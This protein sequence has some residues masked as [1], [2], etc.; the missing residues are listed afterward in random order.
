M[1]NQNGTVKQEFNEEEIQSVLSEIKNNSPE[2]NAKIILKERKLREEAEKKALF[3]ELTGLPNRIGF[4][5]YTEKVLSLAKRNNEPTCIGVIDVDNFKKEINDK[6]GHLVGD[7][8]LV[9]IARAL[10]AGTRLADILSRTGG[11]EFTIVFSNTNLEQAGI[12]ASRIQEVLKEL[13]N[14]SSKF[15]IPA[16]ANIGISIGIAQ[17][18]TGNGI[19]RT[20][21]KADQA[22]YSIKRD[23]SIDR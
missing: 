7:K 22:M 5:F 16:D 9:L 18:Q 4:D 23:K 10:Q 19:E 11:D 15:D 14:D 1:E 21:E 13:V 2:Q 20:I 17:H 8:V 6:Y 12:A 3:D